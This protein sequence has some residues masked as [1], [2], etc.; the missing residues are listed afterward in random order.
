MHEDCSG[1][2]LLCRQMN[3]PNCWRPLIAGIYNRPAIRGPDYTWSGF[4]EQDAPDYLGT[5]LVPTTEDLPLTVHTD[6]V[7]G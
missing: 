3:D 4:G 2:P 7:A 6:T 5:V 1:V